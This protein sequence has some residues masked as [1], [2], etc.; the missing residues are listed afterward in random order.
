MDYDDLQ[1]VVKV[2]REQPDEV[3]EE[4]GKALA[5]LENTDMFEMLVSGDEG[6]LSWIKSVIDRNVQNRM[7]ETETEIS[8]A[9]DYGDF[10]VADFLS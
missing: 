1:T 2:V 5:A 8:D 10:D 7:P 3:S 4:T 6:K 9:T